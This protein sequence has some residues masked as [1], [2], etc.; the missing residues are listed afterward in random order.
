MKST[1]HNLFRKILS[2]M[3]SAACVFSGTAVAGASLLSA[4]TLE[5]SAATT[6]TEAPFSWDNASVY[7]LLTDRFCNGNTSNDHSYGRGLDKNGNIVSGYKTEAA[8][9]GGDFAGITKKL[10]EGYFDDLGV[11]AIWLSAPYEQIHG[12]VVGGNGSPSF[13]HWSY[14]GYYVLDYTETDANF[15]TKE[16]FQTMVDTA[17]EHG[18]RI[19]MDIVM[20]HAGYNDLQTMSE[21]SFGSASGW[22]NYYYSY[23]NTNNTDYHSFIDYTSQSAWAQ[24]WGPDWIRCGL[25]GYSSGYGEGAG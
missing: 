21:Y 22:E 8:F 5:V 24:W 23:Q 11:N 4:K 20:N 16:E 19:V 2:G 10:N 1:T 7:F 14:H 17:H 9:Q 18:I 25:T 12:Y 3:L 15:G 13:P 6:E